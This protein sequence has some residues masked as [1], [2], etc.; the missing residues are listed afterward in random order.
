MTSSDFDVANEIV[1]DVDVPFL[2]VVHRILLADLNFLD[3][4]H[5]GGAVQFLQIVVVLHHV[6][7]CVYGLFVFSAGCKLLRQLRLE[8][9][10]LFPSGRLL[11]RK[12]FS[13]SFSRLFC[14]HIALQRM[15]VSTICVNT[16]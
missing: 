7:P 8:R 3:E 5:E 15:S 12:D 16:F 13:R 2:M 9:P 1:V 10:E 6:Q 14:A 4:P 11:L